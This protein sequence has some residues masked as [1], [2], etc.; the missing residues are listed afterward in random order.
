MLKVLF[1]ASGRAIGGA[2]MAMLHLMLGLRGVGVQPV[3]LSTPPLPRYR[4]IYQRLREKGV[5]IV[6][7]GGRALGGAGYWPLLF[8]KVL[9][10]VR[11]LGVNV[12]HCHGSKEAA[13]AGLAAKLAGGRVLYT[14]EGDPLMEVAYA[15]RRYGVLS[16]LLL[17]SVWFIGLR[18]ADLVVGCSR[19]MAGK[20]RE[21][22]GVEAEAAPNPID[23][24]RF[25]G[26]RGGGERG[27][28]VAVARYERVKGLETLIRAVALLSGKIPWIRLRLVGEGSLRER[29][30]RLAERLGVSERVELRGF[31][32][33]VEEEV[34]RAEVVAL[35]SLYEPFGMAAAEALAAGKPVVAARTGGL[36]EIVREGV[37]GYLHSPGDPWELAER[38]Q[39]VLGDEVVRARLARA[40]AEGSSRFTPERVAQTYRRFYLRLLGR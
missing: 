14:V 33:R 26:R 12:V 39:A 13:V 4:R 15:P 10:A 30:R 35:P 37:D 3:L 7:F 21:R 18:L 17:A 6:F 40:A 20:L 24:E 1:T 2:T 16:R 9:W 31:T 28:V 8:L 38:L 27:V 19:W 11:R 5:R 22:Y 25:A 32:G 29:L 36:R 34:A 23:Y